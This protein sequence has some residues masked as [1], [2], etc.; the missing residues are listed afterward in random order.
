MFGDI[1][2]EPVPLIDLATQTDDKADLFFAV[3]S[4]IPLASP[5][6]ITAS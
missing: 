3:F 1:N 4:L 6:P 2:P 5:T